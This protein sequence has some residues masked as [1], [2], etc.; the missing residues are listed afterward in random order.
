MIFGDHR[1]RSF[2]ATLMLIYR[3]AFVCVTKEHGVKCRG[4]ILSPFLWGVRYC[5]L[6]QWFSK[7]R[8][9][10]IN[11]V[12]NVQGPLFPNIY[13]FDPVSSIVSNWITT[14][15]RISYHA[16]ENFAVNRNLG[17]IRNLHPSMTL[18]RC[19]IHPFEARAELPQSVQQW[20][21]WF[22]AASSWHT[23]EPLTTF[24]TPPPTP[25]GRLFYSYYFY[26]TRQG[27]AEPNNSLITYILLIASRR[28]QLRNHPFRARLGWLVP[29]FAAAPKRRRRHDVW[30]T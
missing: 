17:L 11:C 26:S 9:F 30:P 7:L 22:L 18:E 13:L 10:K 14:L 5:F 21:V 16:F 4:K 24:A 15:M 27:P 29:K 2:F 1:V 28:L 12:Q 20:R 3:S 8:N 19:K 25:S 23:S 6:G